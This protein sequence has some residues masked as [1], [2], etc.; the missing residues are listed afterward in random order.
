[1]TNV[2]IDCT[3]IP[4][5]ELEQICRTLKASIERELADPVLRKRYDAFAEEYELERAERAN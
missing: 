2:K 3:K 5:C 1:M 4:A